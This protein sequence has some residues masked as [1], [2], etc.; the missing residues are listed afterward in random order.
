MKIKVSEIP[1][2]GIEIYGEDVISVED[3]VLTGPVKSEL[4]VLKVEDEVIISGR[5]DAG[6]KLRC[7][8]CLVEFEGRLDIPV[9]TVYVPSAEAGDEGELGSDE[10]NTAFYEGYDIDTDEIAMEQVLLGIP[11]KPLCREDCKGLCP[12]CGAD[13]NESPCACAG[14]AGHPGMDALKDYFTKGDSS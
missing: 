5:L 4:H 13:L 12:K 1:A 7:S 2:E 9:E 10:L 8:R 14:K 11:I 3:V 6:V